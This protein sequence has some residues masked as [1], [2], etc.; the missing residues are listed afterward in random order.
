MA[1]TAS[2]MS[3]DRQRVLAAGF[4][5]FQSKKIKDFVAAVEQLLERH[6]T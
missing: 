4:D 1:M 6:R 5:A 2:V 3:G